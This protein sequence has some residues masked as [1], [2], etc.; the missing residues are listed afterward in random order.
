MQ[1]ALH[2]TIHPAPPEVPSYPLSDSF[3][4]QSNYECGN[5]R[6]DDGAKQA[7]GYIQPDFVFVSHI[8]SRTTGPTRIQGPMELAEKA[9]PKAQ[10][11]QREASSDSSPKTPLREAAF[12]VGPFR[13]APVNVCQAGVATEGRPGVQ[14]VHRLR[15]V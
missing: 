1:Q 8:Q 3:P 6:Q 4:T 2:L 13:H 9:L 7:V 12:A 10:S 5:H 15:S 11:A 14:S